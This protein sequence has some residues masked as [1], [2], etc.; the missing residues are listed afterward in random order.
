MAA[1]LAP[2]GYWWD[3]GNL[4]FRWLHVVAGV[5]WIGSSFYFIALD[6]HLAPPADERDAERGVGGEVWEIHGGGFYRIE[7]FRVAPQVLPEP[8]HWFKWEAYTTWLSGFA[9]LVVVYFSHASTFLVNPA[10]ADLST[11]A[12]VAI[13]VGGLVVAWLVY[14]ALC[15]VLGTN[16]WALAVSVLVVVVIASWGSAQL[17]AARAAYIEVGAMLGTIMAANVF[18]V[19]IPAHWELVR[20]KKAGREPDPRWNKRGKQRSV[21]NNYFTLPVVFAMLSNHFPLTYGS[22]HAW[23]VLVTIMALSAWLRHYFNLRHTGRNAWWIPVTA[24]IGMVAVFVAV[25]PASHAAN[26]AG[27]PP[28]MAQV[29]A[30]VATRCASCHSLA[31]TQPGYS[32]PP[33]G[34]VL[35]TAAEIERSAEVIRSAAVD[36]TAM[37][38][39]NATHMTQAERDQLARWLASR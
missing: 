28:S 31:P 37:P 15:R 29:E 7:K 36:S 16:E 35:A 12:A 21:H 14:D 4:V 5:A 20:A 2:S 24:T 32:E 23:V 19:I 1:F 17:L 25:R 3:W 8:L 30:I 11:G 6:H 22:R 9:L 10:V 38:L 33:A 13:A 27:P 18:F 34:I 26:A 39:G